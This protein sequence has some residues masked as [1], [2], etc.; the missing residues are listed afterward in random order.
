MSDILIPVEYK[1]SSTHDVILT[2]HPNTLSFRTMPLSFCLFVYRRNGRSFLAA[3]HTEECGGVECMVSLDQLKEISPPRI[4]FASFSQRSVTATEPHSSQ[5]KK[6][7]R[8]NN[9]Y[10]IIKGQ[11]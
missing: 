4:F 7:S 10:P 11:R 1:P 8:L 2:S 9:T 6:K 5:R 3:P